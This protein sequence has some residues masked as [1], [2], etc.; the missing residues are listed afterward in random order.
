MN[1]DVEKSLIREFGRR[2][3]H[4]PVIMDDI[5]V[6][7]DPERAPAAAQTILDL[8]ESCQILFFTCHPETT[9]LFREISATI[10]CLSIMNGTIHFH[11]E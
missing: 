10:P 4:L 8:A 9:C 3:E 7:F 11:K 1:K 5:L 2:A 6:N